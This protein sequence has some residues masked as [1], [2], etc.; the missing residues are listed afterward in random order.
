M[1]LG[2]VYQG[3]SVIYGVPLIK[4]CFT[5]IAGECWTHTWHW[6]VGVHYSLHVEAGGKVGSVDSILYIVCPVYI[7]ITVKGRK[8]RGKGWEETTVEE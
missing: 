8:E 7:P 6:D 1:I 4:G 2:P 3:V 5:G